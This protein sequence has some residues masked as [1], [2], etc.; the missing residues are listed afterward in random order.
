MMNNSQDWRDILG[1]SLSDDDRAQ[2]AAADADSEATSPKE[3]EQKG[4]LEVVVER[5]GRV[6]KTATII[7]GFTIGDS[8]LKETA[9]KLRQQLGCGG[10][11]RAGEILLQGDRRESASRLLRALGFKVK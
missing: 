3:P 8:Q 4:A 1:A 6:G 9:T 11:S 2:L 5:K 10:S 7:C